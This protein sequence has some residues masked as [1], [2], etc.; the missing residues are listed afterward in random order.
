VT[1][2][3]ILLF[4]NY[5]RWYFANHN[6]VGK[7]NGEINYDSVYKLFE[8]FFVEKIKLIPFSQYRTES[9]KSRQ[10]YLRRGILSKLKKG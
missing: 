6:I 7:I 5:S 4:E 8:A 9:L 3:K 1:F 10:F 2:D